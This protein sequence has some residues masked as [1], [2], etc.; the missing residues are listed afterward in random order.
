MALP[1]THRHEQRMVLSAGALGRAYRRV[2]G[3]RAI[4]PLALADTLNFNAMWLY[5]AS[6]TAVV[7]NLLKLDAQQLAWLFVPAI[8]GMMLGAWMSGRMAGR[9]SAQTTTRVGYVIMLGASLS[10]L[11]VAFLLP[12]LGVPWPVLL[13]GVNAIG[14]GINAPTVILLLLDRLPHHRGA[15]SSVQTFVRLAISA[16]TAGLISRCCPAAW[17]SSRSARWFRSCSVLRRG[18]GI[19]PSNA[20]RRSAWPSCEGYA[21]SPGSKPRRTSHARASPAS[22]SNHARAEPRRNE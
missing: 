19:A 9:W 14:I 17:S 7:L 12:G 20:T 1:E 15:V 18:G 8:S 10:N 22:R 13:I 21:L 3:D 5:I 4:F 11:F 2:L 16:L 6:A